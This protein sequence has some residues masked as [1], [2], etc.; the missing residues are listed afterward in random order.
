MANILVTG[1][2][3]FVGHH[4][5]RELHGQDIRVFGVGKEP[6]SNESL[7][8][9]VDEYKGCDLIDAD[10]VSRINLAGVDAIINLAG[11]AKVGESRGQG[12][13]Y[14]RVNVGVHTVL[15]DECLKQG[16]SPRIIAV[17]TGAVYDPEQPLP[18]T[19][20]SKLVDT[21]SA[22]EYI[23]SKIKMEQAVAGYRKKGLDVI[24]ARPFNHSG[25][26]Q[27]PGFLL[28]DMGE[29][30]A[31]A[32]KEDRPLL[33]GN[34][35]T[36]RDYTDVRD[37]ARA[38]AL[39]ATTERK[40]L[41]HSV[42]NICSGRSVAGRV[43]VNTLAEAF[44]VPDIPVETDESRVRPNDIMDIYGSNQRLREDT[45]WQPTISVEQ[46]VRD[47]AAWKRTQ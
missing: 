2:N 8:E 27:L 28:P 44:G 38:Y 19:E 15:Y 26:G 3:G 29:Q 4:V 18:L 40:N 9:V 36:K 46:M 47:Y 5:A 11:L 33:T 42:Y 6:E 7:T 34:I 30:I 43:I 41:R 12:E 13:L 45:G 22:I 31:T 25:P 20:K 37:V 16:V 10:E 35:D 1:V 23:A 32:A 17:S 14:D 24:V 39:L 21:D